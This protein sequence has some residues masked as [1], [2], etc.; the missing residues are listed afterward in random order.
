V[1][2]EDGG[3]IGGLTD[4]NGHLKGL[5]KSFELRRLPE[6]ERWAKARDE[7]GLTRV[8]EDEIRAA[9]A[10]RDQAI[11][12]SM[13]VERDEDDG[14]TRIS[15]RSMDFAKTSAANEAYRKRVDNTLNDNQKK[16]WRESGYDNAFGRGAMGSA[17]VISIGRGISTDETN[18]PR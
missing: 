7:V 16:S 14:N 13:N 9:L 10:E 17:T 15:I 3:L 12:E 6:E 4:V 11:E 5:T 2:G 8:Q 18:T 1:I